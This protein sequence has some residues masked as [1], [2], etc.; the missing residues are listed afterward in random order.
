MPINNAPHKGANKKIL[1][2]DQKPEV[3]AAFVIKAKLVKLNELGN[4][5]VIFLKI[6]EMYSFGAQYPC[7]TLILVD[8]CRLESI[9]NT[10]PMILQEKQL[11]DQ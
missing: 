1:Y 5:N 11:L 3:V 2:A 10:V 8:C 9:L 4:T 7:E 6:S